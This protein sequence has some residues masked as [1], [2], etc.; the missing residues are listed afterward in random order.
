MKINDDNGT[1]LETKLLLILNEQFFSFLIVY[2]LNTLNFL[3]YKLK[4]KS[5]THLISGYL[6][7]TKA[8]EKL[9][10]FLYH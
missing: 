6:A 9:N 2:S 3:F 1:M 10:T 7:W 5:L 4:L 8:E